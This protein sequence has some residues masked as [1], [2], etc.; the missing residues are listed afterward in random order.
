MPGYAGNGQATLMYEN[1]QKFFWNNET[2]SVG[3]LSVAYQLRRVLSSFYPWA[4]S[5]EVTF[6]GNP[7]T[8][9][10]DLMGAN[11]DVE[12]SYVELGTITTVNSSYVGRWDMPTYMWPKYVAG[13]LK[14]LSNTVNVTLQVTR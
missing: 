14:T 3:E 6:S 4:L 5:F 1:T 2:V 9:E 12:G 11:N 8:L 13:Y 10:I 7:G